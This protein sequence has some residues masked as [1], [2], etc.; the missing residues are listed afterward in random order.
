MKRVLVITPHM[1]D[2]V[3]GAGGTICRY[4][5]EKQLVKVCFVCNRAYQHKYEATLIAEEKQSALAAKKI[6]GYQEHVFLDLNDEK[7]DERLIDVIIP[8]EGIVQKFKPHI[9][10]IPHKGSSNQDHRAVFEASI[11]ALRSFS[12]PYVEEIYAYEV[13]SSSEQ[14]SSFIENIFAPNIYV[15]I[16]EFIEK[17]KMALECY[18]REKREFPHPRS[19]KAVEVWAMKRGTEAYLEYAEAF[20]NIRSVKRKTDE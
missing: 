20:V 4:I 5:K 2:E 9:V 11:I 18:Q 3:L 19:I 12:S 14:T 10:Y 15:E 7:L 16:T 6:L 13:P 8:I 17:K 1:D